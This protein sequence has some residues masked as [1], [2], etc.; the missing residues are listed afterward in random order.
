MGARASPVTAPRCNE[1]RCA[2]QKAQTPRATSG[3]R[4]HA[5]LAAPNEE[6]PVGEDYEAQAVSAGA[7]AGTVAGALTGAR[8][9]GGIIPVPFVGPVVGA[10]VGGVVGSELGRRLGKAVVTG[11]AAFVHTLAAPAE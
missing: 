1:Y 11:G 6:V 3:A 7:T 2:G 4:R 10:V 8:M 9:L 5:T